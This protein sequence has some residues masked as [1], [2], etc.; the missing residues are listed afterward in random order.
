MGFPRL[1][2]WNWLP[3]LPPGD[4]PNPGIEPMFPVLAGRLFTTEPP[5]KALSMVTS[6][7]ITGKFF[8]DTINREK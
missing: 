6:C 2:S 7:L 1:E 3:F 8:D 5:G 4:L